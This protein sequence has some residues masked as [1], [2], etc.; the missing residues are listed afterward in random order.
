M[1][2]MSQ[3]LI[4]K[5]LYSSPEL[6]SFLRRYLSKSSSTIVDYAG[7]DSSDDDSTDD[8]FESDNTD[9]QSLEHNQTSPDP[10]D[11]EEEEGNV[12][13]SVFPILPKKISMVVVSMIKSV[14]NI[15][16]NIFVFVLAIQ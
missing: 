14:H 9:S 7:N 4:N 2:N 1:V 3:R 15:P 5:N 10:S 11:N 6:N 12:L 16:I 8:G 13:A